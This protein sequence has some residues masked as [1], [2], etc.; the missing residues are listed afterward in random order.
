MPRRERGRNYWHRDNNDY[1]DETFAW[2]GDTPSDE[3]DDWGNELA[4]N[5]PRLVTLFFTT[6]DSFTGPGNEVY[7]IVGF[8][9]FY[10]TGYGRTSNGSWQGGSPDD[11]CDEGNDG[12]LLNGNGNEPPPDID[13]SR[14]TTWA[15]GHFVK[16]VT[17]APFT[18]GGS[19]VLCNP[20]ASFQ[21]C[22]AVLVE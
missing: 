19:G 10:I 7:P 16:D 21:P 11:P 14:N 9:N 2:D 8:G 20:E 3:S 12:D 6:Y 5:D 22:V 18:T 15:W 4:D 1:D 17:P 13:F